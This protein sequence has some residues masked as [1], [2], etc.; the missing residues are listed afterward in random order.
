MQHVIS[1][2]PRK[3]STMEYFIKPILYLIFMTIC[4]L[5]VWWFI[6]ALEA[7]AAKKHAA[8]LTEDV[9]T[10]LRAQEHR[11]Q[12]TPD[13]LVKLRKNSGKKIVSYMIV[14][15]CCFAVFGIKDGLEPP[16]LL[17]VVTC[18]V[19]FVIAFAILWFRD[20]RK[21]S[22]SY[23]NGLWIEQAYVLHVTRN[24]GY[25]LIISYFDFIDYEIHTINIHID[26]ED[27]TDAPVAGD[28][29]SIILAVKG[30][31]LKYSCVAK[32]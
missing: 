27:L 18:L 29:I 11:R 7:F 4:F 17:A 19:V 5:L 25:E 15:F 24:R 21:L 23:D 30:S 26:S 16:Y 2:H 31:R 6:K 3:D 9:K 12:V 28:Y 22:P 1:R 20:K 10:Y 13:D 14:L 32:E 8:S